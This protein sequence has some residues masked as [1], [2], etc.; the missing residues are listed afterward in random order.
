MP[1]DPHAEQSA[2]EDPANRQDNQV[3]LSRF[4]FK[5]DSGVYV[6][7]SRIES[8][9]D[10]CG[11]V[12]RVFSAGAFFR[13]LDYPNFMALLYNEDTQ[14]NAQ[15]IRFAADI[16]SFQPGHQALY[17]TLKIE[18]DEAVYMFEPAFLESTHDEELIGELEDGSFGVVG[19]VQKIVSTRTRLDID[20]FIA[21]AWAQGVRFGI[22][23]AAIAEAIR[24][25]KTT[26]IVV[27][28]TRP[29]TLGQDAEIKEQS[30]DLRRNNAPRKV[31]GGKVDLCQFENR[32]PQVLAGVP[33]LGK[34][35][36]VLGVDGRNLAG[37]VLPAPL[38]NDFD[39]N[40]LCGP[41][42]RVE[43]TEG[44]EFLMSAV[45]G[46]LNIDKASS[47]LSI[48][49]KIINREGVSARTT[50]DLLLTG[51]EYEEYGE[52]QEKRAVECR[53]MT[54]HADV[55]GSI[56]SHGGTI[57]LKK[58]LVGGNATN[59]DGDIVVEGLASGAVLIAHNGCVT[60]SRA[61]SC[62]IIARRIVLG[63]GTRCDLL[64]EEVI[65][66]QAEGCAL[67]G[68]NLHVVAAGSRGENDC[69]LSV[70]I[71]DL[72]AYHSRID[73]FH[74]KRDGVM[75]EADS[76]RAKST[77]L[78][79]QKEV[80]SYLAIAGKLQRKELTLSAEQQASWQKIVA[81]AMPLLRAAQHLGE[82][83]KALEAQAAELTGKAEALQVAEQAACAGITCAIDLVKG[84]TRVRTLALPLDAPALATR[85]PKEIKARLRAT[86]GATGSLF[87]GSSGTFN[88]R[89]A[90]PSR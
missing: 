82:S 81:Q 19:S 73:A 84:D 11:F 18:G 25:D 54:A 85:S 80:A 13:A 36:R 20:E 76:L 63:Q 48:T 57:C 16:V 10:F 68:K 62:L 71:P 39:L 4:I 52:I 74:T 46:F 27:A 30:K 28:R 33:L 72:S 58:N 43:H 44:G 31:F 67:A 78:R 7:L 29:F 35:P 14:G 88:W 55:F 75:Q 60:V 8:A 64:A 66:E 21:A 90:A 83:I 24:G 42:T 79:S 59:E 47:Q 61:D 87:A 34:T 40:S 49:D 50:G 77:E 2:I 23:M 17:K 32:Y 45:G 5:R 65:A 9:A 51:D 37:D 70:L 22:D 56:L 3:A 69:V 26:R 86:D 15:E 41:G 12:N 6:N 1:T 53:S 38:P 89:Y